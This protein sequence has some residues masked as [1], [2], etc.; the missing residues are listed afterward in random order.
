MKKYIIII[1][2]LTSNFTVNAQFKVDSLGR[3]SLGS[4]YNGNAALYIY[5]P[6]NTNGIYC[7]TNCNGDFNAGINNYTI[8]HNTTGFSGIYSYVMGSN[9]HTGYA[10]G[11]KGQSRGFSTSN[12]AIGV[13][14][15]IANITP[16]KRE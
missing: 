9:V 10:V 2:A 14:G 3:G 16:P 5:S 13:W 6:N 1:L 11:I 15:S 4:E 12:P 7:L 8:C